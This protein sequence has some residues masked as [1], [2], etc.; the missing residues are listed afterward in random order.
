ME[1]GGERAPGPQA[2]RTS[3]ET[4]ARRARWGLKAH[5]L[6]GVR[7]S[8]DAVEDIGDRAQEEAWIAYG[9]FE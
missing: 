4:S 1:Q 2:S 7:T 5:D 3:V 8:V 9:S 6:F